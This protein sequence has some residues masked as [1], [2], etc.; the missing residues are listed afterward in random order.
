MPSKSKTAKTPR[1]RSARATRTLIVGFRLQAMSSI[2]LLDIPP[3]YRRRQ[4]AL[5]Y[6]VQSAAGKLI[7][8]RGTNATIL[9]TSTT[10][11]IASAYHTLK[12]SMT[13]SPTVG[14]FEVHING[15]AGGRAHGNRAKHLYHHHNQP[16]FPQR[17]R[18]QQHEISTICAWIPP[19]QLQTTPSLA[20]PTRPGPCRNSIRDQQ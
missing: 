17:R 20:G 5:R 9:A 12:S 14:A 7:V 8:W 19:D 4:R 15:T 18:Q 1:S 6:A 13:L 3:L 10:T 2:A 16:D 11:L